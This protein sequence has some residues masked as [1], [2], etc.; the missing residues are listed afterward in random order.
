[1]SQL[2][3]TVSRRR[4]AAAAGTSMCAT[5]AA[6]GCY[7]RSAS[8]LRMSELCAG[9]RVSVQQEESLTR[10]HSMSCDVPVPCDDD[11]APRSTAFHER[12]FHRPSIDTTPD[13]QDRV[14][15]ERLGGR[16]CGCGAIATSRGSSD[17]RPALRAA[18]RRRSRSAPPS[19]DTPTPLANPLSPM[20][21]DRPT[22]RPPVSCPK[23][24][25]PDHRGFPAP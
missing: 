16:T 3:R 24:H 23:A 19:P 21:S 4:C 1:M 12:S 25:L 9:V 15:H 22:H 17:R 11:P 8:R 20:M 2:R 10:P 18:T 13:N 7:V 5:P 14:A 6:K